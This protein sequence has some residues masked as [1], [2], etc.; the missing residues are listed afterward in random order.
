MF[1]LY[2]RISFSIIILFHTPGAFSDS[3]E[4]DV[5]SENYVE[6]LR[7]I[8]FGDVCNKTITESQFLLNSPKYPQAYPPNFNCQLKIESENCPTYYKFKFINFNIE[9]SPG[10]V[11]DR[12]EVG[13]LDA[14]CGKK[15]GSKEYLAKNGT[16]TLNFK[17]DDTVS[18]TGYRILVTK[19][20]ECSK[21]SSD[22]SKAT[23]K[24]SSVE[25]HVNTNL[26]E[27]CHDYSQSSRHFIM[28]SP[29]FPAS[30]SYP[31]DCVIRIHKESPDVC[32][33][34]IIFR[35]FWFGNS[36]DCREGFMQIDG[37]TVC[38]CKGDF[39][40]ISKFTEN[41][42][43]LRFRSAGLIRNSYSG[44]VAEI[45]QDDCPKKLTSDITNSTILKV[46]N[47]KQDLKF[48][49][50]YNKKNFD[51]F[52]YPQE[53]IPQEERESNDFVDTADINGILGND[54]HTFERCLQWNQAQFNDIFYGKEIKLS[55]CQ[56]AE[57]RK[58]EEK[59]CKRFIHQNG[60]FF[61]PGYPFFYPGHLKICYR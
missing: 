8:E 47:I 46:P 27:C 9:N 20:E 28:N 29:N 42:K 19:I 10:C 1:E 48:Y 32:R 43:V 49:S 39:K 12:L 58:Y 18:A 36:L 56:R 37:K 6:N 17:T 30:L 35:F 23:T 31:T 51:G 25:N 14:L 21:E 57:D 16:L 22:S 15:N 5:K 44:F 26:K 33:L 61:N 60:Y 7:T 50:T 34:R 4:V 2:R 54:A 24:T 3:S 53:I 41:V 13:L 52:E 38:G 45:F 59:N 55:S 11:K 40:L